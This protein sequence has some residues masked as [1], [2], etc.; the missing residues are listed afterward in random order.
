MSNSISWFFTLTVIFSSCNPLPGPRHI[1][2]EKE[3]EKNE[4]KLKDLAQDILLQGS[5]KYTIGNNDFPDT[6]DYPFDEGFAISSSIDSIDKKK[7]TIT[8]Y[9][10]RGLLDHYSAFIFSNDSSA[11]VE[12]NR[13]VENGGND[14]RIEPNWYVVND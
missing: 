10:D 12:F 7:I 14:F 13:N 3:W 6:F 1:N 2:W 4:T 11:L 8:F 9:L 5:K